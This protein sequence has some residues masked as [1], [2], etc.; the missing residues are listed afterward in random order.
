VG[1]APVPGLGVGISSMQA[2]L[3]DPGVS[4]RATAALLLGKDKDP[5]T[6]EALKDALHDRDPKVRAAAVH[7]LSI[8][9]NPALKKDLDP[10]LE[11]DKEEV[12]LRAAAGCLR[13]SAIDKQ[14][15]AR[16]RAAAP[17]PA[18]TPE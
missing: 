18:V 11:D 15:R 5:A 3:T 12:R 9:N 17:E 8:Q 16:K 14:L 2:I 13:L 1:F 10:L 7:S 6:I 4:G